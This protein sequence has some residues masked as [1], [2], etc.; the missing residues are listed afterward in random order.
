MHSFTAACTLL[1]WLSST[2]SSSADDSEWESSKVLKV[3]R[4]NE[5][6]LRDSDSKA[7]AGLVLKQAIVIF[8]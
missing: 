5:E 8:R 1:L 4:N 6:A 7:P 2:P 3:N